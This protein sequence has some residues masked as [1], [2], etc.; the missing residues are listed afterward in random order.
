MLKRFSPYRTAPTDH[1]LFN[2]E[3]RRIRWGDSAEALRRGSWKTF[4]RM[5]ALTFV[6]WI[7]LMLL[8]Y[9]GRMGS[10]F[11]Y[12]DG[13][14]L[15]WLVLGSLGA[16]LI[17]DGWC[18]RA[19]VSGI[20]GDVVG[21]RWDLLRLTLLDEQAILDSK[22]TIARIRA[23]RVAMAVVALRFGVVA[24]LVFQSGV[25]PLFAGRRYTSI[26]STFTENNLI[27]NGFIWSALFLTG[28]VYIIE[29]IWR[30]RLQTAVGLLI[31]SY[32]RSLTTGWLLALLAAFV[33]WLSQAII[34]YLGISL[35][36]ELN[37]LMRRYFEYDSLRDL[38]F[39]WLVV[40]VAVL[41]VFGY[42]RL[43]Q[44]V[45]LRRTLRRIV[46]IEA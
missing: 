13:S 14:A 17:L 7:V 29:P 27:E 45:A 33:V 39:F 5:I 12:Y 41:V 15:A 36:G 19:S 28:F 43:V 18:M 11:W 32:T 6:A 31:S 4:R 22:L 3:L 25:L 24:L 21:G 42:Y 30:L 9:R 44:W 20:S 35:V 34:A 23:W 16:N 37:R 38:I 8:H 26:F 40:V 1:P 10:S 2:F 46:R